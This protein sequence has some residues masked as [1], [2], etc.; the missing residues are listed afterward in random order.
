MIRNK[1]NHIIVNMRRLVIDLTPPELLSSA[2]YPSPHGLSY[3][4]N[5]NAPGPDCS[6]ANGR[7]V[8]DAILTQ[9]PQSLPP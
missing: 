5:L 2:P 4:F 9:N 1:I 3:R 7:L 8:R 6:T